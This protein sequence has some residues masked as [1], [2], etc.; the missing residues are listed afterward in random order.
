M[1][2]K[3]LVI[4]HYPCQDGF[5][6][7]WACWLVHPDWEFYPAIHGDPP[8][9]VHGREVYMLDFSYKK[10]VMLELASKATKITV[11][12]HH[13]TAEADLQELLMERGSNIFGTFD[14]SH[15]GARLAWD[16][17]HSDE[18]VPLLI[19]YVEDRDLWKFTYSATKPISSWL[20]SKDYT[21]DNWNDAR[22]TLELYFTE[23]LHSGLAI[24]DKH[25]KDVLELSKLK[26]RYDI[27]GHSVWCVNV[28]YTYASDM[29]HLLGE[30]EPFA[31]T[32]FY[33]GEGFV[34]SLRSAED[35][36]DVSEIAKKYGGGG[37]KHAAGFKIVRSVW[38]AL[39][40][41]TRKIEV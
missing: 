23:A 34:F 12:D 33:D 9:D 39:P 41:L 16:Y 28:P 6:A 35:G 8:P 19:R 15:S 13:K 26:F 40:E 37:H 31:A 2:D 1:N 32:F 18:P 5:T 20:F 38:E 36:I 30:G 10:P 3:P 4:Y 24:L 14:L 29:G 25:S 11:L 21:F 7:A 22:N 17:F 27:N